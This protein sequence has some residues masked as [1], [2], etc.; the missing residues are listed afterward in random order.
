MSKEERIEIYRTLMGAG[1]LER[2]WNL[3]YGLTQNRSMSLLK[4]KDHKNSFFNSKSENSL[5]LFILGSLEGW[6]QA[7]TLRLKPRD[8]KSRWSQEFFDSLR[9]GEVLYDS[10]KGKKTL[11]KELLENNLGLN[12]ID[13]SG[14]TLLFEFSVMNSSFHNGETFRKLSFLDLSGMN[15]WV[16]FDAVL[17]LPSEK[18]F[19]FFESKLD[20]DISRT[21]TNYPQVNQILRGLESAYL[22]TNHED[23]LY[24]GWDFRYVVICPRVINEYNL[25][26]YNYIANNTGKNL[27]KYNDLINRDFSDCV[28]E[29]C[30]PKYFGEFVKEVRDK[31]SMIYW[32]ELTHYL[33]KRNDNFFVKYFKKMENA[34][35]DRGKVKAVK[36][37]LK[38]ANVKI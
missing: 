14:S 29:S 4:E 38:K 17:I 22:L 5:T 21:T 35:G 16:K 7:D 37:R 32:D 2:D 27:M 26:Y 9:D 20:S 8:N 11:F 3:Y 25:T 33:L 10:G 19:I 23:S 30:Y 31:I 15:S 1:N 24:D 13:S 28:N 36:N 18:L 34:I 12:K 6:Q